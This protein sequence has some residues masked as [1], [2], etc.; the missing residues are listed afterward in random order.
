MCDFILYLAKPP[1]GGWV[2]FTAHLALKYNVPVYK[3][4]SRGGSA[5][6]NLGYGVQYQNISPEKLT[7]MIDSG[8]RPIIS[9]IDKN[10]FDYL[11]LIPDDSFI[12]IHDPTE[13]NLKKKKVVLDNLVRF[14]VITIRDTVKTVLK[15]LHDIDSTFLLHPYVPHITPS[16]VKEGAVSISRI[17][18]DKNTDIIIRANSQIAD[19]KNRVEIYGAKNDIYDYHTLRKM[20]E[21]EEGFICQYRKTFGK[22]CHAIEEILASKKFVVDCS[23]IHQDGGGSQYTFL[24]ALDAGCILI[25]NNRWTSA[26]GSIWEDGMNCLVVGKVED[27]SKK[28]GNKPSA[29]AELVEILTNP[30]DN[31]TCKKIRK[32][33]NEILEKH[34]EADWSFVF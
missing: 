15:D 22:T 10:Y 2:T 1:Y 20:P 12:V 28:I 27:P 9:A 30:P 26:P 5:K 14:N 11:E 23:S 19:V 31:A 17:D 16:E 8:E 32:N 3:I 24:E 34:V 18:H 29:V 25:L 21:Y 4:T 33:A 13:F 7:E 6:Y